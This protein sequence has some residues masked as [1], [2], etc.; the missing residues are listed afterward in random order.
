MINP[1]D[2]IYINIYIYI[3]GNFHHLLI[4]IDHLRSSWMGQTLESSRASRKHMDREY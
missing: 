4:I 1:F 3:K 2:E